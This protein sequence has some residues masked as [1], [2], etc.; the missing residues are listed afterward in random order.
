[1]LN[2]AEGLDRLGALATS[3]IMARL[4]AA[5]AQAGFE[6][7]QVGNVFLVLG[8]GNDRLDGGVSAPEVRAAQCPG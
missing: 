5:F 1:M 7:R 8:A 2:M 4:G 6:T 3:P